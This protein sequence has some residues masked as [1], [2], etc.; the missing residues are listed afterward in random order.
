MRLWLFLSSLIVFLQSFSYANDLAQSPTGETG[1]IQA[2]IYD[3]SA[4]A[5]AYNWL[6]GAV[7]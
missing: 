3:A 7:S 6:T 5:N 2:G 4:S 1:N